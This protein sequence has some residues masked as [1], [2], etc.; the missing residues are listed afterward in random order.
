MNTRVG[1]P[2]TGERGRRIELQE[3]GAGTLK[4]TLHRATCGLTC[5]AGEPGPVVPQIN[6]E[7]DEP[8][9]R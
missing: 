1:A 6:A 7:T 3:E 5:P 4:F 2:G 9:P 8:A